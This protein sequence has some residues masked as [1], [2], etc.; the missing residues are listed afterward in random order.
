[1]YDVTIFRTKWVSI[2]GIVYKWDAA[3]IMG[4]EKNIEVIISKIF[5]DKKKTQEITTGL[6]QSSLPHNNFV[7][8][9]QKHF[10]ML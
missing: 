9:Q 6:I 10:C 2:G 3:V 7:R 5:A 1:M 8:A 4:K